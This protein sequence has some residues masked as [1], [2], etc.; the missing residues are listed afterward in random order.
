MGG[1]WARI[2]SVVDNQGNR[3]TGLQTVVD[4]KVV[5]ATDCTL[6]VGDRMVFTCKAIDPLARPIRWTISYTP[7]GFM[8]DGDL[9]RQALGDE[10]EFCWAVSD[11]DISAPTR[12]RISMASKGQSYRWSEGWDGCLEFLYT[13]LPRQDAVG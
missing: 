2:E 12:V 6:R 13:V 7:D 3:V 8:P 5:C 9:R 11:T 1:Y 4:S 10:V